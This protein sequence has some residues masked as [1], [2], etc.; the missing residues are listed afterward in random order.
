MSILTLKSWTT[1]R[2]RAEIEREQPPVRVQP[3]ELQTENGFSIIR[4][5]DVDKS[6][7]IGGATH[8]FI[9]RD[10]YGYELDITVEITDASV[11]EIINRSRGRLTMA[12]SYWI[13]CAERHLATYLWEQED[14]PPDAKI[15]VD[16]LTP[17]DLDLA[18]RWEADLPEQKNA[19]AISSTRFEPTKSILAAVLETNS[20]SKPTPQPIRFLTENGYS[21][22]RVSEVNKSVTDT[23]RECRLL[24]EN[25]N[26]VKREITVRFAEALIKD[27]QSR[28]RRGALPLTS[29]YWLTMAEKYLGTYVWENNDYPAAGELRIDYLSG[30]DLLLAAYWK[31]G[32]E[33]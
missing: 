31:D 27:I 14:Y 7:S 20:R 24:V 29:K 10:P 23:A 2:G 18:L 25:P 4:R 17:D 33:H 1:D 21:I 6:S 32:G 19:S 12:S 16:Y 15:T 28:R 5:C 26:G 22:V 3:I 11:A 8:S 13:S 30:D 9:V